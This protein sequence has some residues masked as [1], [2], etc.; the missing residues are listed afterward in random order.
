MT[1]I[2]ACETQM[3][4]S[5]SIYCKALVSLDSMLQNKIGV[6]YLKPD[7][8]FRIV[9]GYGSTGLTICDIFTEVLV[10]T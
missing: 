5:A 7:R 1:L 10:A 2:T 3:K 6:R 4:Y 8:A 9:R